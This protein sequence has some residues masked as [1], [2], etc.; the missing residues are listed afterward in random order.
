[1]FR[2][3]LCAMC[4]WL[5][6]I[7][8][9]NGQPAHAAE[10][11]IILRP[12]VEQGLT[13]PLY[14]THAGDGTGRLY[15]VEQAG[16]IR[17][18][19]NH[20]LHTVPFLDIRERVLSGGE[21]GLLGLA[22]HPRFSDNGRLFVNYTR[23]PDGATVISEFRARNERADPHSERVLLTV[24]QPY[25]NHNGGMLAFGPDGFLY[26]A[27]GDGGAAGDPGNRA[28]DKTSLLGK[29]LRLDVDHGTPYA[30]PRDNPFAAGGGRAE[31]YAYG[32]RNPWR[33]SFDRATGELWLADVGQ[34][35]WEE[36]N[37]VERG[38]NYGWRV[39]EGNHCFLPPIACK[40]D[41]LTPPRAEYRN[42]NPRCSI[43]GGYVYRGRAVPALS[44]MYVFGDYCSG[45]VMALHG[46][47]LKVLITSKLRISSFG[48]D[49]QGE[50]YVLDHQGGVYRITRTD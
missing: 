20:A 43:T 26:I 27:L 13:H 14:L 24:A 8:A 1:M 41:G 15:V 9:L 4:V 23:H 10:P 12:I 42:K 16:A 25:A 50:L 31:I 17:T 22:F 2:R 36:I 46:D 6:T 30:I 33:F 19:I 32:L 49:E 40:R 5:S 7:I 21:R 39:M 45:E 18:V 34:N 47:A 28:Q 44:G 35:R 48:E 37:V 3:G 29:L 11:H 38:K